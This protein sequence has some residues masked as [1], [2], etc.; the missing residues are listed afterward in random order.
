MFW[1][2]NHAGLMVNE[3]SGCLGGQPPSLAG[4]PPCLHFAGSRWRR[5]TLGLPGRLLGRG[6]FLLGPVDKVPQEVHFGDF[7]SLLC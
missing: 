5:A 2:E 3:T 7:L 6:G 1:H 4:F